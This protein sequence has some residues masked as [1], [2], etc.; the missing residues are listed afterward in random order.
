MIYMILNQISEL[1]K[2]MYAIG[3]KSHCR[4]AF[5]CSRIHTID[6]HLDQAHSRAKMKTYNQLIRSCHIVGNTLDMM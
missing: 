5:L 4:F 3:H 6:S 1:C 2:N